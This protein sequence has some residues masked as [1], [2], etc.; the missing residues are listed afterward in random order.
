MELEDEAKELVTINTHQGL[1]QFN[2]LPFGVASAPALFQRTMDTILRGIPHVICYIDDILVTGTTK[3][4]HLANLEE[5]LKRL[6]KHGVKLKASKC[7]FFQ[8]SVEFL[9]HTIDCKGLHTT[10]TKVKAVRNAPTPKNKHELRSFLGVV[11]YYGKFIPQLSTLLHPLNEMLQAGKPWSWTPNCEKAF[12][13]VKEKLSQAPILAH[14]DPAVPLRLAGDASAYGVGAVLSHVYQDGTE[15]PIAYASR[16]LNASER[17]YPQLEKEALSLVF[18]IKKFHQYL[19]GREFILLTDHKPLTTILG[20]KSGI[21]SLAAARLQRWALLLSAYQYT[22][23]YRSTKLH[24]NVDG[25]SRLPLQNNH[26]VS[27]S[28]IST[29]NV[30]QIAA[31][32]VTSRQIADGTRRHPV[33]SRVLHYV[34]SGWPVAQSDPTIQPYWVRRQELTIEQGCILWGIRVI[35]PRSLQQQVLDELHNSHSGIVRMKAVARSYVW[36]PGLDKDLEDLVKSCPKCQS[37]R[38]QPAA[39]PLHPWLWPTKPWERVHIDYA[40][41]ID[42]KMML[43][44]VDAH[45]KWPE[46]IIMSS[47]TSQATIQALRNLFASYGLPR[48]LVSDNG[49]QFS[50]SEF[51]IFLRRNGIK[52]IL[53]SPYHPSSNGLAERFVRTLKSSLKNSSIKDTHQHLMDF[54]LNYRTTP[55]STTNTAPCE[56]FLKRPLRTRLDLMRPELEGTVFNRQAMQKQGHDQHTRRLEFFIGQRV[57]VR[58]LRDGPRWLPAT[59]IERRGP[60]SYLVQIPSGAVWRRHVDHLLESNDSPQEEVTA[61]PALSEDLPALPTSQ[62]SPPTVSPPASDMSETEPAT[63][64][65]TPGSPVSE[66]EPE[67]VI[68]SQ[69]S[70]VQK[71]VRRNPPRARKPP[72]RYHEIYQ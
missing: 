69:L 25:L 37:C 47:T 36:W 64:P 29:F 50:S 15:R 70:P 62:T 1:Y 13:A 61:T 9:G 53:S 6:Q 48:Q 57:L 20:P 4:E 43:V 54:L 28:T 16:T 59:V 33:L 18:G 40:G 14:Y 51:A 46:V 56:L 41:P 27:N 66:P 7:F 19:F 32:P 17:N 34:K 63:V 55:H 2:R 8:D 3:E 60:L 39:A 71:P 35:V 58:N 5:V 72:E 38:N 12:L 21:P 24:G 67:S 31:L 45:S 52:H 42:G 10:S 11:H 23:Q 49:P 65:S 22:I 44:V 26:S 68:S 30:H